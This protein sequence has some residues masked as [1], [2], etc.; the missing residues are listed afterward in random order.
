MSSFGGGMDFVVQ[1]PPSEN[2]P[3]QEFFL[4][5]VEREEG[6]NAASPFTELCV[7]HQ[8]IPH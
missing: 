6:E 8:R 5:E 4:K 1:S 3:L 7:T 2:L